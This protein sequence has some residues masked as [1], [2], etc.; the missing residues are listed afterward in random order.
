MVRPSLL[1]RAVQ[2]AVAKA[3]P[4]PPEVGEHLRGVAKQGHP[5]PRIIDSPHRHLANH[6]PQLE[7]EKDGL[8]IEREAVGSRS[9]EHLASCLAPKQFEPAL[10]I[11]ERNSQAGADKAIEQPPQRF[12]QGSLTRQYL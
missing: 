8:D 1:P 2:R 4:D 10:R 9:L 6:I 3:A 11:W 12:P 7:R 5:A